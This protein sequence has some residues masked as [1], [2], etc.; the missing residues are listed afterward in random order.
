MQ[1]NMLIWINIVHT[2]IRFKQH[3]NVYFMTFLFKIIVWCTPFPN[4]FCC[5]SPGSAV[6]SRQGEPMEVALK[7]NKTFLHQN[8]MCC[9]IVVV[10]KLAVC[11]FL[12]QI[13]SI[14]RYMRRLEFHISKVRIAEV[15]VGSYYFWALCTI[16][17]VL[18]V[19]TWIF[20]TPFFF[21][22]VFFPL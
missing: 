19:L 13:K 6:W 11:V 4:F 14:E 18:T 1:E 20:H 7:S 22:V 16:K 17:N 15:S 12:Q 9:H 2:N 5:Y 10:V 21:L 3:K 8:A